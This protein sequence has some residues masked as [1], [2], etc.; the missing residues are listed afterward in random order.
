MNGVTGRGNDTLGNAF[1]QGEAGDDKMYGEG[2]NDELYGGN[3]KDTL[4][5]GNDND[6]LVG[7]LGNDNLVGGDGIDYLNGYGR[8]LT[9]ASQFDTLKGGAGTDYFI[10][11]G[12]WGVSYV[13]TGSGNA[14]ITDWE[15][16]LDRIELKGSSSQ[17][18]LRAEN[19]KV[20]SSAL[21]MAIYYIGG[22]S[23]ALIGVVQDTTNVSISQGH[24]VFV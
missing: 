9:D 3:G 23:Q 17:Y 7:G 18:S 4:D 20:G 15:A 2:G 8:T 24:F 11:G 19:Q 5:G 16:S 1:L 12:D 22:G 10:L 13:E 14:L 6:T 21:D